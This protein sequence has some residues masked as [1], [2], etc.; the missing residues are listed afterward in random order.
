MGLVK[1]TSGANNL[2]GIMATAALLLVK[3]KGNTPIVLERVF[4][5]LILVG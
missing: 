4:P 1:K 5:I 2:L 3:I